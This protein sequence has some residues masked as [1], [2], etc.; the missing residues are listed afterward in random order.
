MMAQG[1]GPR[2]TLVDTR[3]IEEPEN[4]SMSTGCVYDLLTVLHKH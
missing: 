3:P 1:I 2:S 4:K